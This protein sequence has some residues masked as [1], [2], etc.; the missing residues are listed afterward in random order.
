MYIFK[1]ANISQAKSGSINNRWALVSC[2]MIDWSDK[3][4]GLSSLSS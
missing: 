3:L 4:V 1:T 2:L